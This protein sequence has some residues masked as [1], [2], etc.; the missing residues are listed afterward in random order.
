MPNDIIVNLRFRG[1]PKA[2]DLLE[3]AFKN[4]DGGGAGFKVT[5]DDISL[6]GSIKLHWFNVHQCTPK[7]CD[8][9]AQAIASVDGDE[10]D[11][12]TV[13]ETTLT[14][15]GIAHLVSNYSTSA[16][17]CKIQKD[18]DELTTLT[19]QGLEE[20]NG[21]ISDLNQVINSL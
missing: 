4:I 12:R 20:I 21:S 2:V 1:T 15:S 8:E 16:K 3:Q 5:Y 6:Y 14:T 9:I 17:L 19:G 18:L 11:H 7:A 13:V 10:L